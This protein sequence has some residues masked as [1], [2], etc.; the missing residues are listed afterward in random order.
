M[1]SRANKVR[2]GANKARSGN[3]TGKVLQVR[4]NSSKRLG[5]RVLDL[6][7]RKMSG[8]QCLGA[9]TDTLNAS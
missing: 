8:I 1:P 9:A 4:V 7:G 6:V 5:V 2:L 3:K